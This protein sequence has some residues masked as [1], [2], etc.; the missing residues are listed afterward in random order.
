MSYFFEIGAYH[1]LSF[2]YYEMI[3]LLNLSLSEPLKVIILEMRDV[4]I[5][6]CYV[7]W[8]ICGT[9]SH[10]RTHRLYEFRLITVIV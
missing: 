5:I 8:S 1:F 6:V 10:F 4:K 7:L 9:I 2:Y 3:C